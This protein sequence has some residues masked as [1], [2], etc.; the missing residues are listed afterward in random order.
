VHESESESEFENL[1]WI[2]HILYVEWQ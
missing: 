1:P 2:L